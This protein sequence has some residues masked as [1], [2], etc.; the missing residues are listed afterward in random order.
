MSIGTRRDGGEPKGTRWGN[1]R[2][3]GAVAS[4]G[5]RVE[6]GAKHPAHDGG[7][8]SDPTGTESSGPV[9]PPAMRTSTPYELRLFG[10]PRLRAGK[11]TIRLSPQSQLL[12]GL[13]AGS[14]PEG[15]QRSRLLDL[16]WDGGDANTL[17]PR[18]AQALYALRRHFGEDQ[19]LLEADQSIVLN[20]RVVS[21]DLETFEDA[22]QRDDFA[23][24]VTLFERGFLSRCEGG[25]AEELQAWVEEMREGLRDRLLV[26]LRALSDSLFATGKLGEAG[27]VGKRALQ[28]DPTCSSAIA[29]VTRA[30]SLSLGPVRAAKSL[31]GFLREASRRGG[32]GW[33]PSPRL[34]ELR[35]RLESRSKPHLDLDLTGARLASEPTLLVGR[36]DPIAQGMELVR[37]TGRNECS[38]LWLTGPSGM[39][40]SST[41]RAI[42]VASAS[43]GFGVHELHIG[44]QRFGS[45]VTPLPPRQSEGGPPL[46]LLADLGVRPREAACRAVAE[47]LA[48]MRLRRGFCLV[49]AASTPDGNSNAHGFESTV[50]PGVRTVH[51]PLEPLSVG[52]LGDVLTS[53]GT[54][55]LPDEVLAFSSVSKGRPG[56][57]IRLATE[58]KESL[59]DDANGSRRLRLA[60]DLSCG[61]VLEYDDFLLQVLRACAVRNRR[62][63]PTVLSAVL[64]ASRPHLMRAT[65]FLV[66]QGVLREAP[67]GHLSFA[68]WLVAR[69]LRATMA[70]EERRSIHVAWARAICNTGDAIGGQPGARYMEVARHLRLAHRHNSAAAYCIRALS[71]RDSSQATSAAFR[72]ADRLLD[73]ELTGQTRWNLLIALAEAA[74]RVGA[75]DVVRSALGE[76]SRAVP[77][78]DGSRKLEWHL[79]LIDL[80][81]SLVDPFRDPHDLLLKCA[82]LEAALVHGAEWEMLG[83]LWRV[84]IRLKEGTPRGGRLDSYYP[85]MRA[86]LSKPSRPLTFET[87]PLAL[88]VCSEFRHGF[89]SE[90]TPLLRQAIEFCRTHRLRQ[91]LGD[92]LQLEFFRLYH[93]GALNSPDGIGVRQEILAL[94]QQG[95]DKIAHC[96][97]LI[98]TAVWHLDTWDPETALA[99][100][101]QAEDVVGRNAP[102]QIRREMLYNRAEALLMRG[103]VTEAESGFQAGLGLSPKKQDTGRL[104]FLAGLA[105][106]RLRKGDRE[107]ARAA[108]PDLAPALGLWPTDLSGLLAAHV[109]LTN[110]RDARD[111]LARATIKVLRGLTTYSRLW[112]LKT[113]ARLSESGFLS[114]LETA[115]IGIEE[116]L[117]KPETPDL[118][119]LFRRIR[120]AAPSKLHRL[121]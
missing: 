67:G 6:F 16:M 5:Y 10:G 2:A 62:L 90:S 115:G 68:S 3:G 28:L 110:S 70:P 93:L 50:L 33:T 69:S 65:A 79:Q 42:G 49:C 34:V 47:T 14:G 64:G 53:R 30:L 46:V 108:L 19:A 81:A 60:G 22:L 23:T 63:H 7:P 92:A 117:A 113:L 86:I 12:L 98:N 91:H 100:L 48:S 73:A 39:G 41:A 15:V 21:S 85:K 36:E 11:R 82:S 80:E 99:M 56:V 27:D 94:L 116:L 119:S 13:I 76:A 32:D 45:T 55:L 107:G 18:L 54:T 61:E 71:G 66:R 72:T 114:A 57:A 78:A 84:E 97:F 106:C 101:A 103:E 24:A 17:R 95:T 43:E 37:Q 109:G 96:R 88:L 29:H 40:S 9:H 59:R 105:Q 74:V 102:H 75:L 58:H 8:T 20:P 51:L 77:P 120:R 104:L 1:A 89:A 26:A 52:E 121:R 44:D 35:R 83:R 118:P 31:E 112:L 4:R 38:V 87:L 25:G 111:D